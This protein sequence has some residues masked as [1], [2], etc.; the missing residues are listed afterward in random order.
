VPPLRERPEDI[1][2]LVRHFLARFAAEEGKRVRTISSSA[3]QLLAGYHWPGNVRQLENAV[4]RAVVL[5]DG[6]EVG[7]AAFPQI[8]ARTSGLNAPALD[9][10]ADFET[11]PA[12]S[13]VKV[14]TSA[15]CAESDKIVD[16]VTRSAALTLL[17]ASGQLRALEEIE[18][19]VIR[20]AIAYYDGQMS[21][22]A[23]RLRIGR[24]TL[25]RKLET[26]GFDRSDNLQTPDV[27]AG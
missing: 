23:R 27:A 19:E 18:A 16:Q 7:V 8:A 13:I 21:E 2:D 6:D 26:L 4:F 25:Y 5:A 3:V 1:T 15:H 24:S 17:D 9:S 11:A 22:V 10:L 12:A 20:F 14:D